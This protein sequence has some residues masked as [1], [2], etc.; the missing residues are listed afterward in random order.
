VV[1]DDTTGALLIT[2]INDSGLTCD[3]VNDWVFGSRMEQHFDIVEDDPASARMIV[4]WVYRFARPSEGFEV[5]TETRSTLA[6][7]AEDWLFWAD[8][9]AFEDGRRVFARTWDERI[10]RDHN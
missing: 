1:S 4:E 9:E 6:C 2:V 7:T 8:C 5:R 3:P 10:P